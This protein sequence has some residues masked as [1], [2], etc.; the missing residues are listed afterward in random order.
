MN[1]DLISR[2]EALHMLKFNK[3]NWYGSGSM[4]DIDKVMQ[5]IE[6]LPAVDAE[7][8]VRC[9]DCK[10]FMEFTET[11]RERFK[12]DGSCRLLVG[13]TDCDREMRKYTDY[14]S[15]GKR[16]NRARGMTHGSE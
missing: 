15:N 1:N 14:C 4:E 12:F 11:Y 9:K 10:H 7:P 13:F 6:N 5:D 2:D 3:H 16:K 8:V